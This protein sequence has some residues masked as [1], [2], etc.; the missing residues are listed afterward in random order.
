MPVTPVRPLIAPYQDDNGPLLLG[1][2]LLDRP[3]SPAPGWFWAVEMNVVAP[4]IKNR[5]Q[6]PVA[7]DSPVF[8]QSGI[9]ALLP[10]VVHL[11]TAELD[12]TG[13]PRFQLGYR[14]PEGCGEFLFSY[15]FLGSDGRTTIPEF[16]FGDDGLLRSHLDMDVFDFDYGSREYSLDPHWDMKWRAGVRLANIFF[17]SLAE[18]FFREER[19]SNHF[20]G[21]GPHLGLDL[22]RKLDI[23]GLD[24]YIRL[25]AAS[26]V[27][28][29]SQ[30]FERIIATDP[31]AGGA[32][33]VHHTQGVPVLNVQAG[34]SWSPW[35]GRTRLA[36]GYEFERWWYLG[37]AADS[38]AELTTQ[39]I[40]FR[41][42]VGF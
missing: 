16:D 27:G 22:W 9:Q 36:L 18:G 20:V 29:I 12:W 37:E 21:G 28:Q 33:L 38:R 32:T 10:S 11:A 31:L 13:A 8:Q 25:E 3:Y 5:L 14:F 1:D 24:L 2:P 42:E 19:T 15:R 4:Q 23:E 40:F 30:G 41:A 34:L 17:D 35:Y 39:G 6:A 7:I 26:V